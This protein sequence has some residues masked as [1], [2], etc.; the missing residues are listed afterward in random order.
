[1]VGRRACIGRPFQFHGR[2]A[3]VAGGLA[4]AEKRRHGIE[5]APGAGG[6]RRVEATLEHGLKRPALRRR[7]GGNRCEIGHGEGVRA[8]GG[9]Q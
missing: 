8:E 6:D 3:L 9:M 7:K 2:L 5:Q 4:E 1:M